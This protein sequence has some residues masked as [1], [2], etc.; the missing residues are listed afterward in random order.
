MSNASD[1][2]Y[3]RPILGSIFYNLSGIERRI[4][5][6]AEKQ[7]TLGKVIR[8]INLEGSNLKRIGTG[9]VEKPVRI[10]WTDTSLLLRES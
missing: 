3:R 6:M 7:K 8:Q 2:S 4:S 10:L 1:L 5:N 9:K